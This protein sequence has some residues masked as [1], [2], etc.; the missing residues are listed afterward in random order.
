MSECITDVAMAFS[1]TTRLAILKASRPNKTFSEIAAEIGVAP[2]ALTHHVVVLQDA[3]L[4]RVE[5]TGCR[6]YLV[7]RFDEVSFPLR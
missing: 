2:S 6:K 7:R 4:V 1:S 5:Q 3:G